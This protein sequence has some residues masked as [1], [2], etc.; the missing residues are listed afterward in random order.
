MLES[1]YKT[2][3]EYVIRQK[4]DVTCLWVSYSQHIGQGHFMLDRQ[5]CGLIQQD[6]FMNAHDLVC[7]WKLRRL[8]PGWCLDE[9][10]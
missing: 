8:N 2:K 1:R 6:T 7:F 9:R 4:L 10:P 5:A 3:E